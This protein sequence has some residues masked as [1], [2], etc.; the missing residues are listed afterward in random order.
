[1]DQDMLVKRR[2]SYKVHMTVYIQHL[3]YEWV[4][5]DKFTNLWLELSPQT[6]KMT[7]STAS[8][9]LAEWWKIT[10]IHG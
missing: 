3:E 9:L 5:C 6:S 7:E 2:W 4:C 8:L 10:E 1:M